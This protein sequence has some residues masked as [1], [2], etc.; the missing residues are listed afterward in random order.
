MAASDPKG[1][2][3]ASALGIRGAASFVDEEDCSVHLTAD[4]LHDLVGPANQMR[5]MADLI[6]RR[7]R[8]K[9]GDDAE[10]LFGFMQAASDRLQTL[11]SGLRDHT[12]IV[13][14]AQPYRNFDANAV[15]EGALATLEQTL[16]QSRALVTHDP[17]PEIC[18]DPTQICYAFVSLIE[19]AVKFRA[20]CPP[21]IHIGVAPAGAYWLFSVCDNGIGID[22]KYADRIFEVFK[23]VHNDNY[24]GAGMGL[25]IAQR[26]IQRHGGRIWVDSDLGKGACFFFTLPNLAAGETPIVV[27]VGA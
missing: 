14:N 24:P 17:L 19:N 1:A 13:G 6:L 9:L 11:I 7:H 5:S 3:H 2:Q 12:R 4:A 26:I 16:E 10:T 21:E 27:P 15:L 20:N 25:P 23:R 18:G 8:D 22:R